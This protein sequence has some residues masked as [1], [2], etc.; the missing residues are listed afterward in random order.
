M[1]KIYTIIICGLMVSSFRIQFTSHY[2]N[3]SDSA[4]SSSSSSCHSGAGAGA[5]EFFRHCRNPHPDTRATYT[6]L[7]RLQVDNLLV[8]D[9]AR[10]HSAYVQESLPNESFEKYFKRIQNDSRY[11]QYSKDQGEDEYNRLTFQEYLD[12][13]TRDLMNVCRIPDPT[14]VHS[15]NL[16]INRGANVNQVDEADEFYQ[17]PLSLAMSNNNTILVE[18]LR[19]HNA[20]ICPFDYKATQSLIQASCMTDSNEAQIIGLNAIRNRA[21]V[22]AVYNSDG[23]LYTAC[24][25]GHTD[26]VDLLLTHGASSANSLSSSNIN[27]L[28]WAINKKNIAMLRLLLNHSPFLKSINAGFDRV[29]PLAW[30]VD[31]ALT[32]ETNDTIRAMVNLLVNA[33]DGNNHPILNMSLQ[34]NIGPLHAAINAG[35]L[36]LVEQ[37]IL[38]AS[39]NNQSQITI[40]KILSVLSSPI[41]ENNTAIEENGRLETAILFEDRF[42]RLLLERYPD[43]KGEKRANMIQLLRAVMFNK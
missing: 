2:P 24:C 1:K 14:N 8:E 38:S 3:F 18:L 30:A 11:L 32:D 26:L 43:L 36:G 7:R 41:D 16:I 12:K 37:I 5:E 10:I 28:S 13:A 27:P 9:Y 34:E 40:N 6:T 17:T 20:Q 23:I 42:D 4:S 39:F 22:N 31:T 29:T 15:V 35:Y 19:Q 21:N 25:N 33:V